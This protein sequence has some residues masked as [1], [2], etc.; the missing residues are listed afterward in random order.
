MM[1]GCIDVEATSRKL[2]KILTVA[3][4]DLKIS[5]FRHNAKKGRI[6]LMFFRKATLAYIDDRSHCVETNSLV[7]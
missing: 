7:Q 1:A 6:D 5:E 2:L 3:E 4:I